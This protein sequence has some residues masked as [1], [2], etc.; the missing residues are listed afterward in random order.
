MRPLPAP[1]FDAPLRITSTVSSSSTIQLRANTYSVP[2]HLIG[3]TLQVVLREAEWELYL[4]THRMETLP[5]LC[6]HHQAAIN[7]WHVSKSLRTKLGVLSKEV[8]DFL[9]WYLLSAQ[10]R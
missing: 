9:V 7:F 3:Q 10:L 1:L 4:G 5:R 8:R 2:S 6:G